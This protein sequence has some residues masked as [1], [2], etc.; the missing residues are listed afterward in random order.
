MW[1]KGANLPIHKTGDLSSASNYRF[2]TLMAVG[3]KIYSRLF[4]DTLRPK[5][6]K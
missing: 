3:A 5:S 6:D 4:L 1:L 2:I